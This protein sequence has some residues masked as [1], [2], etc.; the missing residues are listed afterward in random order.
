MAGINP[1]H[2]GGGIGFLISEKIIDI[3][4]DT[5]V[6]EIKDTNIKILEEETAEVKVPQWIKANAEWWANDQIDEGTFLSGIEY[7]VKH[8]IIT[9]A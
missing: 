7:L 1:L 9:V 6:S 2:R 4:A 3:P 5:N 8:G